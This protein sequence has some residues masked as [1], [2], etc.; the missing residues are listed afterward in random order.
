MARVVRAV[1]RAKELSEHQAEL[2]ASLKRKRAVRQASEVDFSDVKFS[3]L[4][5]EDKDMLLKKILL[6]RGLVAPD[7]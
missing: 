5:D 1:V 6:E 7:D 3:D 4:T 2:A